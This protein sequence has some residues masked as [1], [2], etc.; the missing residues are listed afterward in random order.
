MSINPYPS[1]ASVTA[2]MNSAK[3][4]VIPCQ[5]QKI[6]SVKWNSDGSKLA[7]SSY[8]KTIRISNFSKSKFNTD[9]IELKG[10][11][12]SVEQIQF[13]PLNPDV[14][15]SCSLDKTIKIWDIRSILN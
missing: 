3:N 11:Q 5:K 9:Q 10:H 8:D 14:I 6:L 1:I 15:A 12:Q 4:K 13:D 7:T 2:L